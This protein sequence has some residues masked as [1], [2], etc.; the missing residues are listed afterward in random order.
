MSILYSVSYAGAD[1][2][3]M[4]ALLIGNG[5]VVGFDGSDGRYRGTYVEEDGRLRGNVVLTS[6]D[7]WPLVTGGTIAAGEQIE[8]AFDWPS[9][10]DNGEPQQLL[11]KGLPITVTLRKIGEIP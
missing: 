1:G 3:G 9:N 5:H 7:E 6:H 2:F 11:L 10:F 4:A 8:M